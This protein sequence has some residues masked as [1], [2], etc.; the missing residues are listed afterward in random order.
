MTFF[1]LILKLSPN[2]LNKSCVSGLSGSSSP[3]NAIAIE[4]ASH[5]PI[6]IGSCLLPSVSFNKST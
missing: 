6:T 4:R 3:S 1:K 2:D 5:H